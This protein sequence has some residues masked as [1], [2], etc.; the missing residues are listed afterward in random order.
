MNARSV[1]V[2]QRRSKIGV[3]PKKNFVRFVEE[4]LSNC[5]V[6]EVGYRSSICNHIRYF[7]VCM[8]NS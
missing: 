6:D 3:G 8:A 7:N 5:L 2:C 4:L 1:S